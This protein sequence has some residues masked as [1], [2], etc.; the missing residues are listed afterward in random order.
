VE[1]AGL[2]AIEWGG[3]VHVPHGQVDVAREVRRLTLDQ[4]L[5]ISSYGSY[6]RAA[7]SEAEGLSFERVLAS[8]CELEA[9]IIRVWAGKKG[10][11]EADAEYWKAVI[12]DSRRIA[13]MAIHAGIKIAY[14]FHGGTLTDTHESAVKLLNIV[15]HPNAGTYWQPTV[16]MDREDCAKGL[17]AILDRLVL[18]HVFHWQVV[19]GRRERLALA[20]G[21]DAWASY[22]K[23]AQSTGRDMDALIEFV[24]DDTP[25]QF[26]ADARAL[27]SWLKSGE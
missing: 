10:S 8:A 20:D 16:G 22:L 14:E 7:E 25:E 11:A 9:P 12:A 17:E 15:N 5:A 6:Y 19:G 2:E 4:G 24:R 27:K 21:E 26:L 23:I 3:D 18:L 1:Q 13:D